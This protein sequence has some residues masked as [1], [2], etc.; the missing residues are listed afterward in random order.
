MSQLLDSLAGPARR[1]ACAQHARRVLDSFASHVGGNPCLIEV[2]HY[3]RVAPYRG[4]ARFA[5]SPDD[6]R[7]YTECEF[8]VMDKRGERAEWLERR[9]TPADRARI[10]REIA[11]RLA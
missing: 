5:D 11:E 3:L 8:A 7:G 2:T 1:A 6:L 10:E 4:P 9:I